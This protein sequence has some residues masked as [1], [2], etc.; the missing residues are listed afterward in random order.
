MTELRPSKYFNPSE[1]ASK[2]EG[3][4]YPREWGDRFYRLANLTL[5][6]IRA[7]LGAPISLTPNGG[8]SLRPTSGSAHPKGLAA[9]IK[10]AARSS[11]GLHSLILSMYE[12]GDLPELG[13]LGVY[14]SFV[15]VDVMRLKSGR[16]RRWD[17]R[18]K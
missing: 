3:R 12:A 5:D 2:K 4:E 7:R 11:T 16:L 9:D 13:G 18:T 8:F 14:D 17:K 15:H 1:W 6:V 10:T